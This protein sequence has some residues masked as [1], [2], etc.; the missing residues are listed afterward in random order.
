LGQP[1]K[2]G[3]THPKK[4][5]K[6]RLGWI[7]GCVWFSKIDK[8]IKINEFQVKPDSYQKNSFTK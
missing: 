2:L 6:N 1:N 3:Q 7:I 4:L 5:K 8:P